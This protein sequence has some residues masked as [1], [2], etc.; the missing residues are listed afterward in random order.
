[1][2]LIHSYLTEVKLKF[3]NDPYYLFYAV[4]SQSANSPNQYPYLIFND[5]NDEAKILGIIQAKLD[6]DSLDMDIIKAELKRFKVSGSTK[7]LKELGN[8]YTAEINFRIL[9]NLAKARLTILS[10]PIDIKKTEYSRKGK[11]LKTWKFCDLTMFGQSGYNP[12][13]T[14]F[15][16]SIGLKTT[17]DD[18]HFIKSWNDYLIPLSKSPKGP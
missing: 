17:A 8:I 15:L 11:Y 1:M 10:Q 3:S 18:N 13:E 4:V 16:R 6:L 14:K 12:S 5:L 7:K 2:D 9:F